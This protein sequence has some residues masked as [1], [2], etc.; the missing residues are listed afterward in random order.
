MKFFGLKLLRLPGGPGFGPER[1]LGCLDRVC[2]HAR[3]AGALPGCTALHIAADEG[4]TAVVRF[5]LD[6]RADPDQA[7]DGK[8]TS[9]L[10]AA[11]AGTAAVMASEGAGVPRECGGKIDPNRVA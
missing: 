8:R 9:L 2:C 4:R 11:Q 1:S 5:L 7:D 6:R 10:L 3:T